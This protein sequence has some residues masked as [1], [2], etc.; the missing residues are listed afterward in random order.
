MTRNRSKVLTFLA[1]VLTA[2]L[3]HFFAPHSAAPMVPL[4]FGTTFL[5]SDDLV[6]RLIA[7]GFS[8]VASGQLQMFRYIK[9]KATSGYTVAVATD[10][11][12][13]RFTNRGAAGTVTYTL[14]A[15][16]AAIAGYIYEFLSVEDQIMTVSAGTGL[17]VTFNNATAASLTSSTSGQKIGALIIAVCD[18]TSWHL[19]G[20]TVGVTY[21][22]A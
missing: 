3:V 22:V 8:H 18:G 14:P 12:G 4:L 20:A 2:V 9:V 13:T 17:A 5:A 19:T 1:L 6:K 15:P 16:A 21:T 7:L 10:P 11:S